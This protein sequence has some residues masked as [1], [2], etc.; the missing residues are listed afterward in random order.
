MEGWLVYR[1]KDAERNSHYIAFYKEAGERHG[2]SVLLRYLEDFS[3]EQ[4]TLSYAGERIDKKPDFVIMRA[5]VPPFSEQLEG[6]GYRVFNNAYLSCVANDKEKT[7]RLASAH[8]IPVPKTRFAS[9]EDAVEK[10]RELGFPLVIKPPDG[11]G[12]MDVYMLQ[13]EAELLA[14]LPGYAH[15][16]FLLQ[17]PVSEL[18][19]DLRVYVLGGRIVAAMLRVR[20]DDFRS[21]YCLGGDARPY[22]LSE[23]ERQLVEQVIG[24]F[25]VDYAGF[26]FMFDEGRM[27]LNEIE[28]V[29]GARMLYH[30]TDIDIVDRYIAYIKDCLTH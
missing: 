8:G 10:A 29:V 22:A 21:N 9:R 25:C 1:R 20:E 2:V 11:H 24:L 5:D 12:G 16:R 28:D 23:A 19:K 15:K 17:Q 7:L 27:L 4:G 26:D 14:L 18:G 3:S 30:L 13:T 6:L